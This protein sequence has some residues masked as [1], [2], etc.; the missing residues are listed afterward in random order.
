MFFYWIFSDCQQEL[1]VPTTDL[2]RNDLSLSN[3]QKTSS[4][5]VT[6]RVHGDKLVPIANQPVTTDSIPALTDPLKYASQT[7]TDTFSDTIRGEDS[8][9]IMSD[10]YDS[11]E[12]EIEMEMP[13]STGKQKIIEATDE[14]VQSENTC[15]E[16][17][18]NAVKIETVDPNEDDNDLVNNFADSGHLWKRQKRRSKKASLVHS[19]VVDRTTKQSKKNSHYKPSRRPGRP[20]AG[21]DKTED[22]GKADETI[23]G[24]FNNDLIEDGSELVSIILCNPF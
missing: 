2:I 13:E 22:P 4:L 3:K 16:E 6:M 20:K 15:I 23:D 19:S 9:T 21:I 10:K 17:Q 14:A 1:E 5:V 18:P 11:H 7:N 24:N 12:D 8:D